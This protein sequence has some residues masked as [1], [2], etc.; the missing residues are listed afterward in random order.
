MR[1]RDRFLAALVAVCWGLNFIAVDLGLGA[2]P[3]LFLAALRYL[4]LAVPVMLLVPRPQV[5]TRWLVLY[6]LGFGTVQFGLLF[7]AIEAGMPTGLSSLV[8]QSSAPLT[9]LLAVPLLGEPVVARQLAGIALAV[10][11][12][13]LIA[14]QQAGSTTI[15][16]FLLTL[17]AALGWAV[18]NL[19][20]RRA[21]AA[22]PFRFVLWMSVVP[23]LPLLAL[24]AAIEGPGAGWASL[25]AAVSG[26]DLVALGS[27]LYV[28]L[29]GTV[30]GS[31]LWTLL[32]SRYSAGVVA[33]YSMLVPVVALVAAWLFLDERP[34]AGALVGAAVVLVGVLLGSPRP[35]QPAGPAPQP[36]EPAGGASPAGTP[37]P[38]PPVGVQPHAHR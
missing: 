33:P 29:V 3:P 31:G 13:S 15:V 19:A 7:V 1:W 18:G 34:G 30:L 22:E 23:P 24:S 26:P 6:G 5:A 4:L 9:V 2:F 32:M 17:L 20:N 11:G 28:V 12:L 8:L 16:P 10:L 36:P 35:A 21:R 14:W 37:D 25:R 38:S 27:I